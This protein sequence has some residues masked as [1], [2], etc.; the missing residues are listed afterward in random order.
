MILLSNLGSDHTTNKCQKE[1][2]KISTG[3]LVYLSTKNLNLPKGRAHKLC[4]E[5]VGPYKIIQTQPK[6][7]NYTLELPMALQTQDIIP[8][9][10][11]AL[12]QPYHALSDALFP[13]HLQ[14]EPYDF[15]AADN[16]EWFVDDI[17]S[18]Q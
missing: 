15:G 11:I 3:D 1:E 10:H 4:P 13:N 6:S 17:V 9:F 8:T 12:L 18:H 5:F 16:Q 2:P 7:S 14:P